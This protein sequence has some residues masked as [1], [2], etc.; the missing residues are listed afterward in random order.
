MWII[1][2]S[3]KIIEKS[4]RTYE[5]HI[6]KSKIKIHNISDWYWCIVSS[7]KK[8]NVP[9]FKRIKMYLNGFTSDQ[10]VLY[11]FEKNN[12]KEYLTDVQR[13]KSREVNGE[14]NIILDDKRLFY[15]IFSKYLDIPKTIGYITNKKFQNYNGEILQ[16]ENLIDLIKQNGKLVFRRFSD[17]GGRGFFIVEYKD[18]E[19]FLSG[20]KMSY[21]ELKNQLVNYDKYIITPFIKQEEYS[22]KIYADSVNTIRVVVINNGDGT[23]SV[24]IALHRFG[25]KKSGFVDNASSGGIFSNVNVETGELSV[26]HSYFSTDIFEKHP[27]TNEQIKGVLIPN[28]GKIKNELIQVSKKFPYINIIAWD[29]VATKNGFKVIEAN[30]ST[31]FCFFQTEKGLAHS[32]LGDFYKRFNI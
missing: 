25:S 10:Y 12:M 24:P 3:K 11:N 32:E 27:D 5:R 23:Y 17:G 7:S 6:N 28:W 26:A 14:Y 29:V 20:S 2:I 15:E 9:F 1:K 22:N 4:I 30:T 8:F 21:I 18:N 31:G 13:W 16:I 19:Y